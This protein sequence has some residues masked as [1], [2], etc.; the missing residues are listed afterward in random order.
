MRS[1]YAPVRSSGAASAINA[2]EDSADATAVSLGLSGLSYDAS[3]GSDEDS[4]TLS[5][6]LTDI[7][8]FITVF[9]ADGSTAVTTATTLTLSELA[10]LTYKTVANANGSGDLTWVVQDNGGTDHGGVDV[11]TDSVT[12]TVSPVNDAPSFTLAGD[13]NA[14]D[15][16]TSEVSVDSFITD[17]AAGPA[18]ESGQSLNFILT[19]TG[20]ARHAHVRRSPRHRLH[21]KAD[22]YACRQFQRHSH[23]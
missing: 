7:P 13:P 22:L 14:V 4:Q 15:E 18:N 19:A 6:K 11:L 16:D 20:A 12:I 8:A 21:W 10:G 9:K 23:V 1:T 3:G 5:A 2:E 17:I